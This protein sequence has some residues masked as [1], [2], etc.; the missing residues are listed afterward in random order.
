MEGDYGPVGDLFFIPTGQRYLAKGGPGSQRNLFVEMAVDRRMHDSL[1][2]GMDVAS[3]LRTCLNMPFERL[4]ELLQRMAREIHE[5]GFASELLIEGLGVTLLAETLRL[6]YHAEANNARKGG[7]SPWRLRA[8]EERVR[9]GGAL[10]TL[11]ELA[12]LCGLSRRQL[13]RAFREETGRT[14]GTFVQD[15]TMERAKVLLRRTDMPIGQVAA[16]VGFTTA[17]SF[18]TAFRRVTGESPRSFRSVR[19]KR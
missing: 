3:V 4:R 14:I 11:K 7:L 10:P 13:M 8:I 15:L 9:D 12:Q 2:R 5:P 17:T 19:S 18:S 6:L 1:A 16:E